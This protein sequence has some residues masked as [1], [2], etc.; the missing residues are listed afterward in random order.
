MAINNNVAKSE[1]WCLEVVNNDDNGS[2]DSVTEMHFLNIGKTTI[3]RNMAADM[4]IAS[5]VAS[6]NH[7]FIE[8]TDSD[9]VFLTDS[10]RVCLLLCVCVRPAQEHVMNRNVAHTMNKDYIT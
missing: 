3:G 4:C 7:C 2:E 10:V 8:L 9:E 5:E 6:R 1:I